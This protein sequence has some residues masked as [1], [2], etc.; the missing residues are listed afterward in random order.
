MGIVLFEVK[1]RIGF[2]T[3][4]RPEKRN[5]LSAEMVTELKKALSKAEQ[6]SEVK[7]IVLRANGDVFSAGADLESLQKL[8]AFSHEENKSDS[9]H[10]KELL[11]QIYTMKKVVIAM[12]QGHAIAGGCGLAT[13]CDFIFATPQVKMGY[14]EVR[15]GFV[16]AIVMVFLLRRIG[17]RNAKQL[18]LSGKL[19]EASEAYTLGLLNFVQKAE[20]LEE[21]VLGFANELIN[22][23]SLQSMQM[24]KQMIASV[25]SLSLEE[26][27]D[28]AV[29][30]NAKARGTED[31]KRGIAA[32]L[33]K[34]KLN[35]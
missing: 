4:N 7:V 22:Q 17:E 16:P 6:S 15:I 35:W 26:G 25:Q 28:F 10:L 5:A 20:E 33:N 27:L 19:V 9:N 2:V 23:N 1:E 11:L 32:F 34:E 29:E 30:M 12:L 3:L 21:A 24:T 8:Q 13:V 18:L 14:T 31:C